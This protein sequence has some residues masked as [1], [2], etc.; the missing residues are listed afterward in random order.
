MRLLLDTQVYLWYLADSPKL[1]DSAKSQITMADEVYVSSASVWEAC[2]KIGIGK[3]QAE[4]ND[5]VQGI[6]GSGF[7]ELPITA[8]HAA[9][10]AAL[11]HHHR[12]PFDRL[13][14]AQALAGPLV[15]LSSDSIL[16]EYTDLAHLIKS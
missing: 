11:P 3:L 16:T 1:P 4:P 7:M 10:V 8:E 5:L 12:D 9:A 13:L 14:I 6:E 15:L 2:I